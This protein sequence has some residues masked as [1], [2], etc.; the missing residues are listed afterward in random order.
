MTVVFC[1]L[2]KMR[3]VLGALIMTFIKYMEKSFRLSGE[4]NLG[5][6]GLELPAWTIWPRWQPCYV[7]EI[8]EF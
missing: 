2:F 5:P 6:L 4:S 7:I 8:F 1:S 3:Y